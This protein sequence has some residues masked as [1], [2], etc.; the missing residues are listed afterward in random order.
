MKLTSLLTA[1]AL[2]FSASHV[3]AEAKFT[4]SAR[5]NFSNQNASVSFG[6]DSIGNDS[7]ENATGTLKVELWALAA[8]HAGGTIT[9]HILGD[10]KLDGLNPGS[11]YNNVS[12]TVKTSLPAVKKGYFLCLTLLQFKHGGY[13]VTDYR[14]FNSPVVLGPVAL[15]SMAGPWRWHSSVEGGTLHIDV[16]KISHT[17][18]AVTGSLK[19]TAWATTRPYR[20]GAIEGYRL[21]EVKKN[22]LQ[23]GYSYTDLHNTA[24]FTP[25]PSGL[26][27]VNL[28]LSEFNGTDY[29]IEAYLP[30]TTLSEFK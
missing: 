21:G 17:R 3:C 23:P 11:V 29:R 13:V 15:F 5:Y 22:P 2:V 28:V 7:K 27:Y 12:K 30:S 10:Y 24:K 19:L 20:G 16:A 25:P 18:T 26:Y 14:N 9:G 6:C 8:P 1:S 4:G